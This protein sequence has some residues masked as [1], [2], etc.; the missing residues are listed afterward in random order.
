M[1][2]TRRKELDRYEFCHS[3]QQNFSVKDLNNIDVY[4]ILKV[5]DGVKSLYEFFSTI[6]H[7]QQ[8]LYLQEIMV[9]NSEIIDNINFKILPNL[10]KIIDEQ[11]KKSKAKGQEER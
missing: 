10:K 5:K 2:K 4:N 11:E 6:R 1:K 7:D 8:L 3:I 9:I